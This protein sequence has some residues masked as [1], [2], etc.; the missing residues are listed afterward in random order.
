[1]ITIASRT[2]THKDRMRGTLTRSSKNIPNSADGTNEVSSAR[3]LLAQVAY[4][5]I[6]ETIVRRRF[7]LEKNGGDLIARNHMSG[8][9]HQQLQQ[10]ELHCS[11]IHERS[12]A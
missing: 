4:V 10:I 5:H 9:A 1:M 11:Q 2:P 3:Q 12:S 6:Q 8:R 7:P